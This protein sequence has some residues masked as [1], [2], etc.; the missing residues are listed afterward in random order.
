MSEEDPIRQTWAGVFDRAAEA[1]DRVGPS[2]F[3]RFGPRLVEMARVPPGGRALDV[4]CGRGAILFP[5]AAAVGPQGQVVG[6]DLSPIMVEKTAQEI[7]RG[8]LSHVRVRTMDAERLDFPEASFDA[9]L[10]GFS[11]FFFPRPEAALAEFRR[12]LKPGG[13][14]AVST[15]AP[16]DPRWVWF[17]D[18]IRASRPKEKAAPADEPQK[19]PPPLFNQPSGMQALLNRAGFDPVE[20]VRETAEF[21][22]ANLDEWWAT[23]WSHGMREAL[24][25]IEREQG[26]EALERFQAAAFKRVRTMLEPDGIHQSY[27]A[28]FSVAVR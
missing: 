21:V 12:V 9:V 8:G 5:L 17:G 24:E 11:I 2:I 15:W 4:A 19:P 25:G 7:Q 18:L 22:Y 28:L 3:S 20:V 1:Y 23:Q 27:T 14:L 6:I 16:M 26:P 10:C 13:R